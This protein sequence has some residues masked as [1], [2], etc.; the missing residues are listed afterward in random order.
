MKISRY[1]PFTNFRLLS[2]P[3]TFFSLKKLSMEDDETVT[4]AIEAA[5]EA[6]LMSFM[7]SAVL[8][9]V[10]W[11]LCC[12]GALPFPPSRGLSSYSSSGERRMR[13]GELLASFFILKVLTNEK[14]GV[15]NLV[16]WSPFKLFTL[17]FSK[18][19]LQ[20]LHGE[21]LK[22]SQRTLFL[23]FEINNCLPITAQCRA[24]IHFS[25]HTHN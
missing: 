6:V 9:M 13:V 18:E 12:R 16:N 8:R 15:L 5:V 21:R 14:R 19:S 4:G 3:P 17:E 25:H 2:T 10:G 20:T 1:Y 23:S 22:I 24:A 11:L 7:D